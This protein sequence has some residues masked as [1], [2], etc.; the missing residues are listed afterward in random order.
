[1]ELFGITGAEYIG[2][3]ASFMV[4]LSF[5]MKD[6]VKLRLVNMMGCFLFVLYGFLIPSLRV[7]LPIII[8]NGAI[9]LVNFYFA[10]LKRPSS[11]PAKN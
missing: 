9:F 1:M 6:V 10:V 5:T 7:G 3:L 4:L 2:Y 11:D 8:A